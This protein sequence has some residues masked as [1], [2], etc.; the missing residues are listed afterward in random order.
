MTL[1]GEEVTGRL[2]GQRLTDVRIVRPSESRVAP[3]CRHFRSCGGCA[4]Q[5]AADAFVSEWKQ[6]IVETALRAQGLETGFLPMHVSPPGSRRRA[7]FS[8]RRTK[9]GAMAGFHARASGVIV[10]IPDC[11]LLHP[12]LARGPEIAADLAKVGA[13][14][15]GELAAAMTVSAGGLDVDVRGGLGADMALRA[16]LADVAREGS[17]ARLRWEGEIVFQETPPE[18]VFGRARVVPP[19]GAFL[20]ATTEGE[21]ALVADVTSHLAG[22]ERIA[23]LFSGCGTFTFPLAETARVHAV[24]GDP[25]M[26]AALETAQRHVQGLKPVTAAVRDLFREP[27]T[28]GELGAFDGICLDPPRAG[29]EAQVAEIARSGVARVAYVSCNPVSFARDARALTQ[30]GY[31]MGHVRVVDQFRWSPHVELATVFTL[32]V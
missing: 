23:D 24:E 29:A 21:A 3:P 1:P 8:A 16:A 13:S 26:V 12:D 14:R 15:R 31:A 10:E 32:D 2:E 18:Q 17:L 20:Q 19:P 27:L 5:H 30:A 9:K 25:E 28:A 11:R 22:A 4:V 7:T 6:G